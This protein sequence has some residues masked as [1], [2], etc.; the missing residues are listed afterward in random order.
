MSPYRN[1]LE[2]ENAKLKEDLER[3]MGENTRLREENTALLKESAELSRKLDCLRGDKEW[4]THA[5]SVI[6]FAQKVS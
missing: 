3:V 5:L 1:Y 2:G 4:M 6:K